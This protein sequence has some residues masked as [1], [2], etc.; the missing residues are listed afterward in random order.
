[1]GLCVVLFCLYRGLRPDPAQALPPSRKLTSRDR[2]VWCYGFIFLATMSI[3][4]LFVI[5][6]TGPLIEPGLQAL[7]RDAAVAGLRGLTIALIGI[8]L[9]LRTAFKD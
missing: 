4:T 2:N 3:G 1:V 6:R 5:S 9:V 8:S 7:A